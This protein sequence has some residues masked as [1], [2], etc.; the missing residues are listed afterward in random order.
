MVLSIQCRGRLGILGVLLTCPAGNLRTRTL[1][2]QALPVTEARTLPATPPGPLG[3]Y[4]LQFRCRPPGSSWVKMTIIRDLAKASALNQELANL[5]ARVAVEAPDGV[6]ATSEELDSEAVV[7]VYVYES[8]V[9][10]ANVLLSLEEQRRQGVL[11]DVTLLVE[12]QEVRAHRAVLAASSRYFLQALLGQNR[13]PGEPEP[14]INLPEKVTAKG[15]VPLL[16]F[17]YTAKLVLSQEN[18]HEVIL[19]ADFLGVHNLEDSCFRF[20]QAQLL[21]DSQQSSDGKVEY[22]D[23]INSAVSCEETYLDDSAESQQQTPPLPPD[24]PPCPTYRKYHSQHNEGNHAHVDNVHLAIHTS[25]SS[26]APQTLP[27]HP[28]IKE[29]EEGDNKNGYIK[30]LCTEEVLEMELEVEEVP[31]AAEH[32]PS[33][34]SPSSYLRSYLERGGLDLSSVPSTTIQQLLTNRLSLNHYRELVKDWHRDERESQDSKSGIADVEPAA[35]T[36]FGGN[37]GRPESSASSSQHETE[38]DRCSV[39]FSSSTGERQKLTSSVVDGQFREKGS[40]LMQVGAPSLGRLCLTSSCPVPI[41]TANDSL[42]PSQTPAQTSSLCPSFSQPEDTSSGSLPQ[43]DFSLSPSSGSFSGLSQCPVGVL[44]QR[45]SLTEEIVFSQGYL[46]I[47]SEQRFGASGENSSDESGSFSEGDSDITRVSGSEVKLPFPVDQITNLPRND[48]QILIKMH[49]LTSDQLEFIHDIRRRSKNR[50]A[51]Q[52]C[53][54]RKL[55]CI[56]NLETEILKLVHEKEKLLGER[57]QLK[58]CMSELRRDLSFLS[59]QVCVHVQADQPPPHPSTPHLPS[60]HKASS[61]PRSLDLTEGGSHQ[62]G[63]EVRQAAVEVVCQ[64]EQECPL[65]FEITKEVLSSS[66][67]VDFCQEMTEKCTTEEPQRHHCT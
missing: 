45:S 5:L 55:D 13:S 54:K 38:T 18:I 53:R 40:A 8:K 30:E 57:D 23:I 35:L 26:A 59:Q 62:G 66:V 39:I 41:K 34:V 67:T 44:E 15:F 11:C 2:P 37:M 16:Q 46:K 17:A 6:M 22:D 33:R 65:L 28:G 42:V 47:K 52:R 56:Q 32:S 49:R 7:P 61:Q 1:E 36:G 19:C 29:E 51:A 4:K 63:L 58:L 21:S 43:F 10:C 64:E 31:V 60:A 50:V 48:F 9:H 20:L 25:D 27:T 12:G 14:I 24:H 3:G